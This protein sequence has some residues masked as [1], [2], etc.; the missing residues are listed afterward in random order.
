MTSRQWATMQPRELASR[1]PFHLARQRHVWPAGWAQ[2]PPRGQAWGTR[3]GDGIPR[4]KT[5]MPCDEDPRQKRACR[6]SR[7]PCRDRHPRR[8]DAVA[9]RPPWPR[10]LPTPSGKPPW[11][12]KLPTLAYIRDAPRCTPPRSHRYG[13]RAPLPPLPYAPPPLFS[14]YPTVLTMPRAGVR[15]R[16]ATH[17]E[18]TRGLDL[19]WPPAAS[20]SMAGPS[21][22]SALASRPD[23]G[24]SR[25]SP[26]SRR[27]MA[28][29]H[30]APMPVRARWPRM[31]LDARPQMSAPRDGHMQRRRQQDAGRASRRRRCESASLDFLFPSKPSGLARRPAP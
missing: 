8:R 27:H 12:R 21:T 4:A 10:V 7:F 2:P 11:P 6:R 24:L 19:S 30:V 20:R 13:A 3:E 16:G 18:R 22:D 1:L 26:P 9:V 28:T 15:R 25:P 29:L 31:P 5:P 14:P 23:G 17:R